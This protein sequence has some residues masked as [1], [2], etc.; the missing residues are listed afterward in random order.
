MP[1]IPSVGDSS[2]STGMPDPAEVRYLIL[3]SELRELTR[4]SVGNRARP[5]EEQKS[6]VVQ[7]AVFTNRSPFPL[8][9]C[10]YMHETCKVFC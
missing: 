1:E 8:R 2:A 5:T 9:R 7:S 10:A 3:L 4:A 6:S